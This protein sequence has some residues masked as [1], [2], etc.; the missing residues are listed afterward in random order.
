MEA[1]VRLGLFE[2][3]G[4]DPTA[5]SFRRVSC[6]GERYFDAAARAVSHCIDWVCQASHMGPW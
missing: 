3:V 2:D 6:S 5:F 4:M 1:V